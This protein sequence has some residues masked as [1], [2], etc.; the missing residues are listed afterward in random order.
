MNFETTATLVFFISSM[1]IVQGVYM[2][3]LDWPWALVA[4]AFAAMTMWGVV[5]AV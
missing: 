2:D 5:I 4:I 3:D 1:M